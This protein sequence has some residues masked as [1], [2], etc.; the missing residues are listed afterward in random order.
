MT[1]STG[2]RPLRAINEHINP[3][4]GWG[5]LLASMMANLVWSMP[6]FALATASLRQNLLP[7]VFGAEAMPGNLGKGLG[8]PDYP[9]SFVDGFDAVYDWREG[10]EGV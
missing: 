9:G 7:D 10:D 8:R 4:L 1:L 6:Q 2:K 5:W 3:V